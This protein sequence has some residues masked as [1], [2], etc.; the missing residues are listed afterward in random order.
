MPKK[1]SEKIKSQA[2]HMYVMQG[3][4]T[5]EISSALGMH[6]TTV[7]GWA[8]EHGWDNL[9]NIKYGSRVAVEIAALNQIELIFQTADSESR[10]LNASET[11][12]LSKLQKLIETTN[13]DLAFVSNAIEGIAQFSD[14]VRKERPKLFEDI[15]QLIVDFSQELAQKYTKSGA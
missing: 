5:N 7:K 1:Y 6:A 4:D 9:R 3:K 14:Y 12:Q 15:S 13:S 11:D 8:D 2:K 10:I